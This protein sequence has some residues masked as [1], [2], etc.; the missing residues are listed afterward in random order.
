MTD[1]LR[2]KVQARRA[3]LQADTSTTLDVP[4][5]EGILRARYRALSLKEINQIAERVGKMKDL[6]A[7]TRELYVYADSL[8]LACEAVYDAD[9]DRSRKEGDPP[10]AGKKWGTALAHD[11]GFEAANP[12]QAVFAI[13]ARDTQV[14]AQY[15][16]VLAWMDGENARIDEELA[17]ESEPP[18]PSS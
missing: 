8:V 1:S 9:L 10:P 14:W 5:Y 2:D 13:I 6:D 3:E 17:G 4:G 7:T 11:L 12:R 18:E 15:Q 16:T